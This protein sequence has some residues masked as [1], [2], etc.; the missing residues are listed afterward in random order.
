MM[1]ILILDSFCY[2]SCNLDRNEIDCNIMLKCLDY[3]IFLFIFLLFK[4]E[5][6]MSLFVKDSSFSRF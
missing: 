2:L 1:I 4:F 3:C 6:S 5:E